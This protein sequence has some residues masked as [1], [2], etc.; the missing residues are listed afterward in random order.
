MEKDKKQI[1]EFEKPERTP[2]LSIPRHGS[3]RGID[4][5]FAEGLSGFHDMQKAINIGDMAWHGKKVENELNARKLC[6][7]QNKLAGPIID[8]YIAE[9]ILLGADEELVNIERI[10]D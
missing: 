5:W 10:N 8:Q 6:K 1:E 9:K 2:D 4:F 3:C 7:K